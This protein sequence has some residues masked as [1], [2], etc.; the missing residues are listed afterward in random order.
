[1]SDV[2]TGKCFCGAVTLEVSGAPAVM[3]YCHCGDCA[4]WAAAPVTAFG[5]W[6]ADNVRIAS[7]GNDIGSFAKTEK[8]HRK[9]CKRCGGHLITALPVFDLVEV[10]P[11][12]VPGL[13]YEPTVHVNYASMTLPIK[14]G[15]PKF[16][17]LPADFG[18]SGELLS[19]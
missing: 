4:A 11:S 3:G 17:D 5:M 8:A 13:I 12:V 2:Y 15:L 7:G 6:P 10:Y 19:E 18:G 1:M 9:F 14:D 16:K